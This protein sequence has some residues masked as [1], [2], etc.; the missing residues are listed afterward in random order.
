MQKKSIYKFAAES[1]VPAGLYLTLMS[2]CFLMSIRMP[3]LP[4]LLLPL[5]IGFPFVLWRLLKRICIAEPAYKKFSSLWL[6]GIYTVI[7]GTLICTLFSAIYMFFIEPGFVIQYVN[8]AIE[9]VEASPMA[10]Q[11]QQTVA[12]MKEAIDNHIL[13]SPTEFLTT[14]AWLTCFSGSMISLFVALLM[15]RM[16]GKVSERASA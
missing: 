2:A 9:V 10:S 1:G 16:S 3:S 11:Y 12:L 7:F 4:M 6:A 15:T 5:M 14:M 8:N 13:P